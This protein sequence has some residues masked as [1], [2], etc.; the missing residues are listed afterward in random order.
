ME[1]PI[2]MIVEGKVEGKVEGNAFKSCDVCL[3]TFHESCLMMW[4][5][6][7]TTCPHCRQKMRDEGNSL[8][9]ISFYLE[10]SDII[11]EELKQ[12][13]DNIIS[14]F[15]LVTF[16]DFVD[17][18]L[19]IK[20]ILGSEYIYYSVLNTKNE[21]LY[22]ITKD[23]S[24]VPET[25]EPIDWDSDITISYDG[26]TKEYTS[27]E[28]I[29]PIKP[30]L[31]VKYINF[32]HDCIINFSPNDEEDYSSITLNSIVDKFIS[33]YPNLHTVWTCGYNCDFGGEFASRGIRE[34]F[35]W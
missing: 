9:D 31:K 24:Q 11:P 16:G 35:I 3:K 32:G 12:K 29:T 17:C 1:C 30:N 13:V 34:V 7:N 20:N 28:E 19:D 25:W 22:A 4:L 15:G 26:D 27:L 8:N 2:C 18:A 33:M 23:R 14:V 10:D 21:L 6:D 5:K